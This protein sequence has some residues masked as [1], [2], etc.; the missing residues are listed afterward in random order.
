MTDT[1]PSSLIELT[2]SELSEV[3]GGNLEQFLRDF[4]RYLDQQQQYGSGEP[5]W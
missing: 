1:K 5:I 4:Q 2:E 3:A